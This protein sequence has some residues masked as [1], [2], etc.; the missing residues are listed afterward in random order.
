MT[1]DCHDVHPFADGELTAEGA[2]EFRA[3]LA[4]CL[5]CQRELEAALQLDALGR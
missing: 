5:S 1:A 2:E 4:T 3:H